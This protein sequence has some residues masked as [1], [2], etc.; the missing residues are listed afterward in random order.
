MEVKILQNSMAAKLAD[1][2]NATLNEGEGWEMLNSLIV[3]ATP[4]DQFICKY[5]QM[6]KR[7]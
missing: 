1:E 4:Q 6:M 7:G 5:V 3:V 2:I